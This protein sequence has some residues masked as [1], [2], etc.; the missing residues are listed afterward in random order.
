[1]ENIGMRLGSNF[2]SNWPRG[3]GVIRGLKLQKSSGDL[4]ICGRYYQVR[5]DGETII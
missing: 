5:K 2:L 1:M 3:C 4:E